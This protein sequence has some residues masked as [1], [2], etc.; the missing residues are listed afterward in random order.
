MK[1]LLAIQSHVVHGYVGNKAATF[2]LQCLGWEVD[3]L[4][5]VHFSN[6]TGYGSVKGTKASAQE[7]LDIYE[8]LKL[9]GLSYEFLLTGYVPGEE[10][11][12]AVGKVGED[13]KNKNPELIWLLD[14]VLG[15]AGRLY[16]SEKTIPV[17]QEI[18]KGGKVTLVTPNQFEAELLTGIKIT[19][20]E[21]LK[22]A[23]TA[24]HTTYKTP[25]V[26]ISSLS[27]SDNDDILYSAG[28]T[29]KDGETQTYIY[30]FSKINSYFTGTGDIF[31]AL[32][33]D[34][35]YTYHTLKPVADPLRLAVGEV[36][37]VVQQIL[38]RT[39]EAAQKSGIKRGEI[40]NAESMKQCEL[41]IIECKDIFADTTVPYQAQTI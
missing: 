33:S 14:P 28:S 23:L 17:Y 38:K 9:A 5:T 12:E 6:N 13:V 30:E 3:A 7:I 8:G 10:G 21:T 26:A 11:V 15:D 1:H 27:F 31:A 19:D 20:R 18:L 22:Q 37:G 41:C 29:Q 36:L 39:D 24:L 35:F 4:N 2:P 40:G 34:R 32:L 16:V 25:Y